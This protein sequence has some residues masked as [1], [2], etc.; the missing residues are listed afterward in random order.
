MATLNILESAPPK[1]VV[2][3]QNIDGTDYTNVITTNLQITDDGNKIVSIIATERG[4]QGPPGSGLPGP[5]GPP[6]PPGSGLPGPPGPQG[7]PGSGL[8]DMQLSD[9]YGNSVTINENHNM[10]TVVGSGATI[11]ALHPDN[12]TL[13]VSS[14]ITEGLYAPVTHN[15]TVSDIMLLNEAIDDRV[16][17]LLESGQHIDIEYVDFDHN[18][19]RISVTGLNIG[20]NTQEYSSILQN[21]SNLNI[22]SGTLLYGSA[23]GTLSLIN[24]SNTSKQLLDDPSPSAQRQTLGLGS[25][26]TENIDDFA[27]IQ[28]GN[29][30]TGDQ[31]FGDGIINRFS[32]YINEQTGI[33]YEITQN[34][35]GK[36]IT[37]SNNDFAVLVT[38]SENLLLGFNCLIV[39]GGQGQVRFGSNIYNRY[40]HDKLVGQ[41]SVATLV[42]ISNNPIKVVLSGDTTLNNSGP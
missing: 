4:I 12:K 13:L 32:A 27:K 6:G 36:V 29:N 38:I 42:K 19:I 34:D 40:G 35:N 30:F 25:I 37:L 24:L 8:M 15:H 18:K 17:D 7:L 39:Q 9:A 1:R 16:G 28:G 2:I 14:P 20:Q 11:V 23:D 10:L 31:N 33:T 3:N 22:S 21:I 26:A 41:Y 5:P